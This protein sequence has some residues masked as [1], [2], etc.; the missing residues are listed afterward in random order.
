MADHHQ[1]VHLAEARQHLVAAPDARHPGHRE[2]FARGVVFARLESVSGD[3]LVE[4]R[5]RRQR[6]RGAGTGRAGGRLVG[7]AGGHPVAERRH[8]GQRVGLHVQDVDVH[9][10]APAERERRFEGRLAAATAVDGDQ[11]GA[12]RHAGASVIVVGPLL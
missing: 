10:E 5:A 9:R 1:V 2:P 7:E 6:T 3:H 11:D 12:E 4:D 8:R